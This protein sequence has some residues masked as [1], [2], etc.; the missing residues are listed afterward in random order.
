[1]GVE[2]VGGDIMN[3]VVGIE[4]FRERRPYRAPAQRS[5]GKFITAIRRAL[6]T[7]ADLFSQAHQMQRTFET[8][9]AMNDR[10]LEDMGITRSDIP[11]VMARTYRRQQEPTT[12]SD[13]SDRQ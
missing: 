3:K 8:I 12:S 7:L 11:A 6:K 10:E 4:S 9:S 1:V 5:H 13:P 2:I